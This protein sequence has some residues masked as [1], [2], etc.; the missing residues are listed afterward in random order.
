MMDPNRYR[1][2]D[3]CDLSLDDS[4]ADDKVHSK[5]IKECDCSEYSQTIIN[6][7]LRLDKGLKLV[8][9]HHEY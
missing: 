2:S 7:M 5:K 4:D 1:D 6:N 3:S 9:F 8:C